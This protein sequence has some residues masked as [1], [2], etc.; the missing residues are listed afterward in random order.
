MNM[1]KPTEETLTELI[2]R[3]KDDEP[4][5]PDSIDFDIPEF[6]D[7]M[8]YMSNNKLTIKEVREIREV[9][10]YREK[11]KFILKQLTNENLAKAKGIST[12]AMGN[13]SANITWK[14][15]R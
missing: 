8:K 5:V 14:Q 3:I 13:I 12:T 2:R 9:L 4:K 15:I 10:R 6:V 1:N 7:E 11:I